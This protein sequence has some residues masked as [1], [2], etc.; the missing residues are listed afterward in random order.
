MITAY[1]YATHAGAV[2]QVNEDNLCVF[3]D[4][5]LFAVADGMGGHRGGRTA[6]RITVENLTGHIRKG[7]SLTRAIED[8]HHDILRAA[9]SDP[10]LNGMGSTVVA[11]KTD[12]GR[13]DIAW[14]GDSRAY[15]WDGATLKQLTRDHSYVQFL[16]DE[17]Q[18]TPQEALHH[19]HRN[20]ILQALGAQ[21]IKDVVPDMISGVFR[22]NEMIL[23][24]SD[25]LTTELDDD[26][27]AAILSRESSLQNRADRLVEKAISNGGSDNITVILVTVAKNSD[28]VPDP[29]DD[30][31]PYDIAETTTVV[32][33]TEK[34]EID[35]AVISPDNGPEAFAGDFEKTDI[36]ENAGFGHP[37]Q[38]R[39]HQADAGPQGWNPN[40]NKH[41][42]GQSPI[43]QNSYQ[44][45]HPGNGEPAEGLSAGPG[46][47][48]F[49][50]FC[51][52]VLV[53]AALM[54]IAI[55]LVRLP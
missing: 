7:N 26:G 37:Y 12:N 43:G 19:S 3:P 36:E 28:T 45:G 16:L 47:S 23:L 2:R 46:A 9:G 35:E 42:A 24:C 29:L 30:T 25:G 1:G 55:G 4:I 48:T 15:V 53:L 33:D 39:D 20:I 34:T 51:Y 44:D 17:G 5:G 14:V 32:D 54:A 50:T 8:I 52:A 31:E 10:A 38:Q 27:I 13:Y 22:E 6:S 21:D 11:M 49:K 18:I 41:R 40:S